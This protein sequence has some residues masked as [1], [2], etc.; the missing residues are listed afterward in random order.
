MKSVLRNLL[1]TLLL[2]SAIGISQSAIADANETGD[3]I[4]HGEQLYNQ[5]CV[6]CHT[7]SVFTREN[8]KVRSLEALRKQVIRCRDMLG[9]QLFDEDTDALVKYLN[10]KYYKF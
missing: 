1:N 7:D 8:H 9:L 5:Y 2:L 3:T 6:R 4:A 10:K